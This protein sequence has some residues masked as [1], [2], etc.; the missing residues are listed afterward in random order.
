M[1]INSIFSLVAT[2]LA[3]VL[4]QGCATTAPYDYSSFKVS[5]PK[6]ILILP[7]IN[8]S[9]DVTA[10]HSVMAQ[11]TRP[12]AESGYYVLPVSLVAEAFKENGLTQPTD[13]HATSKEKLRE[14][15]GADAAFYI[16][17]TKF[18]PVYTVINS[19]TL[20]AVEGRLMDLTT[21][22]VLWTGR[23]QASSAESE[24]RQSGGLAA[25]L[26]TALVKQVLASTF[27]NGHRYA[28]MAS[29]RLLTAGQKNGILY[30][31]RSPRYGK[32]SQ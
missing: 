4:L 20:V 10:T 27:E 6:S 17:V 23:A 14:I 5:K 12:L 16:T 18:G 32:D 2:V 3:C 25:M 1:K 30:G 31:P 28:G 24:Q 21:G 26:I 9:P 19:E 13:M 11:V 15:F 7:P 8:N 22:D 29:D